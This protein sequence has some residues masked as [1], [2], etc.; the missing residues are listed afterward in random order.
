MGCQISRKESIFLSKDM[1]EDYFLS[2]GFVESYKALKQDR[3]D[4]EVEAT[5]LKKMTFLKTTK[6]YLEE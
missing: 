3:G 4:S 1:I 5:L 6:I 2:N